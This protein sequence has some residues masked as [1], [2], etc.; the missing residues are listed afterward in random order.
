M[1][2]PQGMAADNAAADQ[3]K[4]RRDWAIFTALTFFFG[5]G[6]AVYNGV[7][8]N[9]LRD[10]MHAGPIQLGGLESLREIPGLLA[11]LMAGTLV[12]LAESRIAGL[13]L[14]I[15]AI[16]IGSTGLMPDYAWLIGAVV[17]WSAGFH[18]YS[19]VSPA[20]TL[21][22]ARGREGG[23][24]LGRMSAVGA[25]ATLAA[26]GLASL[27]AQAVHHFASNERAS[28]YRDYYYVAGGSILIASVL[29]MM[30]SAHGERQ[31]RARIILRREYGLYYLLIFLEGCRRQIFSIF[32][33][34]ALILIY[35]MPLRWMLMIQFVN[36]IMISV[37]A[38]AMGRVVD[39]RGEKKPLFYYSIGLIVVFLG[40]ATFRTVGALIALFL[41]DNVLFSFSVGYTTYL[42]RIVRKNELTPCLAMG[43]TMNHIAAVSVPIGGALLW[44]HFHDYQLPFWVG[45]SIACVALIANRWLPNGPAPDQ[46]HTYVPE[47]PPQEEGQPVVL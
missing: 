30:L 12:S 6:F 31:P 1:Q 7:F 38:P 17:F 8:Q 15:V 13:G 9:W 20:I 41:I 44:Y 35:H 5:F 3:Q 2:I 40:Y 25:A 47:T 11:A 24:H 36:A 28:V 26:L 34:F 39:R 43:T 22:L 29:C 45:V 18:L 14:L 16:G 19:T 27:T 46:H 10:R 33:S 32:A 42:N 21:A 37:T 4:N 23:R